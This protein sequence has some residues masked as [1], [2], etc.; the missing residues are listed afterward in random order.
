[1][2]DNTNTRVNA[3]GAVVVMGGRIKRLNFAMAG[4][5]QEASRVAN[6]PYWFNG[7]LAPFIK[8][9]VALWERLV[10]TNQS[11]ISVAI[12]SFSVPPVLMHFSA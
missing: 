10:L 8:R 12:G 2:D 6:I 9:K 1:M 7:R 4:Q 11:K 3:R 5:S